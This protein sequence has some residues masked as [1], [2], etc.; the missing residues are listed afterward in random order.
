MPFFPPIYTLG[1]R[2]PRR[3]WVEREVR[4]PTDE[5]VEAE[6][7]LARQ[8]EALDAGPVDVDYED[9]EISG[10]EMVDDG[11]FDDAE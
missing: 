9:R 10:G 7:L 11:C 6:L 1:P 4:T 3:P 5:E 2:P 8:L